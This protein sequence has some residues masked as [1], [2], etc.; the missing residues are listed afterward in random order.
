LSA[1][2]TDAATSGSSAER[3]ASCRLCDGT[4]LHCEGALPRADF[5]AGRVLEAALPGGAIWRCEHCESL[6]RHPVLPQSAYHALYENGAAEQWHGDSERLDHATVRTLTLARGT[7]LRVLDV[8]CGN[9]DFLASL[10]ASLARFGIEPS[11]G[12]AAAAQSRGIAIAAPT[13]EALPADAR[14]DV[15]T[16]I[17]VI[18]HLVAPRALLERALTHLSPDGL[19]IVSTGDP[20]TPAWRRVFRARFWY[21]SFPEHI[22]FPSR[23]WFASWAHGHGAEIA[24]ERATRYRRLSPGLRAVYLMIQIVFW[25]SPAL[26]DLVGRTFAALRGA[27][28]PRR[29]HFSPGVTGLF[30][31][32]QVVAIRRTGA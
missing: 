1:P 16:V 6:F 2:G 18:E 27:P 7:D 22:S 26:L 10:P 11:T 30:V 32:H 17:D 9:G 8:G 4:R 29:R 24:A 14:F 5:F 20:A 19:L 21:S 31:D 28:R 13:L 23:T 15:I 12:A 25:T 3:P